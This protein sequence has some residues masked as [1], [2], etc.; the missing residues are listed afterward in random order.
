MDLKHYLLEIDQHVATVTI[1]RPEK[2]NALHM[3]A[4]EE[5]ES[6]FEHLD[7]NEEVRAVILAGAGKHFCSGI[8]LELLMS[9]SET[10][11]IDCEGRKR[12][13]IRELILAL[14]RPINAIEKCRKPVIAA[15]QQGC[16]GAGVDI[17]SA[18]DM[19]YS[20]EDAYFS[21]KEIDMGMVADLGTLQRLPKI[22]PAGYA[23]EMAFTGRDV[24]A[25]EALTFG[26]VNAVFPTQEEMINHVKELSGTIASKSPLSI[27]GIKEN[28]L[29]ARDHSVEDG[30]KYIQTWNAAFLLSNDLKESFT[31]FMQ[32]K[33]PDYE[34]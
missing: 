4:W 23:S 31:A 33:T 32:K 2:A 22:I 6:I 11:K 28:L 8:D 16:I 34:N 9:V 19:R 25:S 1:H 15:I 20:T 18:C 7:K 10:D 3:P 21:I 27:R 5:L 24:P 29:Y 30:L 26:L 12:E 13:V 17:I 14:Q